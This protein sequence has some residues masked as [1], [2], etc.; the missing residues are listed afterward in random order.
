MAASAPGVALILALPDH[1][2]S[3]LE[4]WPR[5][6][7]LA[8]YL[9]FTTAKREDCTLSF[10][11]FLEPLLE[12]LRQGGG[13]P[14]F[15]TLIRNA[16]GWADPLVET[17][18][19]HHSRGVTAGM[20]L[21]C[22]HTLVH[23][24]EEIIEAQDAPAA[25][26]AAA[27]HLVRRYGDA[28]AAI[29]MDDWDAKSGHE[30][31]KR[32]DA[33]N[34]ELTL[35]KNKFENMLAAISDMVLVVGEQGVIAEA[36]EAAV[37]SLGSDPVG[38]TLWDA[39][40][41]EGHSMADLRRFYPV[42]SSHEIPLPGGRFLEM[43]LVPLS[44]VSLSSTE[45][46]VV[47]SDITPHVTQRATLERVVS[48]RTEDLLRE[49]SQ[50]EEMNITLRHV[51]GSIEKEREEFGRSVAHTV[52]TVMLPALA[53][54]RVQD[55]PSVRKG[56]TDVLEDQ[57]L[58]LAPGA[59]GGQDARLLKLTPTELKICRFLQAGSATKDIAEAM[60]LSL[61]TIQTHRKNI[62]KKL[63]LQGQGVSLYTF[64]QTLD[65]ASSPSG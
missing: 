1:L 42:E 10:L 59:D 17:A 30:S 65:T 25:E 18:R 41:L 60:H 13:A 8:G 26:R 63:G 39:L 27:L 46:L 6:M 62:R 29:V 57:L 11:W 47:L 7:G 14:A 51:L 34:R 19:R 56:Y 61:G 49:K 37:A 43:K 22:L 64:L 53:R 2:E 4:I 21:G 24:I 45:S 52:K 32:L 54:I 23:S 48:Q 31:R 5:R 9:A 28:Y 55:D 58:R 40:G 38:R 33:T 35:G 44:A 16:D 3:F 20:F 15:E 36:N 12:R 50:L